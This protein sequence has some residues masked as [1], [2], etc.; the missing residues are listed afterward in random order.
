MAFTHS[1][2][3]TYKNDAGTLAS[4]NASYTG[5]NE[6]DLSVSVAASTTLEEHDIAVT[7]SKI[8][9]LAIYSDQAVVLKT[10]SGTSPADTLSLAAKQLIVWT[11]D[12]LTAKPFSTDVTKVFITN[13]GLNAASVQIRILETV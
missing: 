1:V 7:L 13:S 9:S 8:K 5:N 6:N 2:G 10:N 11:N 12:M 4:V 3:T